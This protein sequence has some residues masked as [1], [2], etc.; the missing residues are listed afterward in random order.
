MLVEQFSLNNIPS[1]LKE[2]YFLTMNWMQVV[3]D[4]HFVILVLIL[5]FLMLHK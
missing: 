4:I 2:V 5:Q 1:D 3:Q